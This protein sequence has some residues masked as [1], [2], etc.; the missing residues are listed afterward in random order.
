MPDQGRFPWGP[1]DSGSIAT[2]Q[3]R[4]G[5]CGGPLLQ[6]VRTC[7]RHPCGTKKAG[8]SGARTQRRAGL[9]RGADLALIRRRSPGE[10]MSRP[11]A[12]AFRRRGSSASPPSPADR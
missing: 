2:A 9:E 12:G 3:K 5:R 6:R 1:E 8:P 4:R 10:A 7:G 11:S